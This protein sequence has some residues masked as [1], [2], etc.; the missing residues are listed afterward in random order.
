MDAH[1]VTAAAF[2]GSVKFASMMACCNAVLENKLLSS[3]R[4][5]SRPLSADDFAAGSLGVR[6]TRRMRIGVCAGFGS[7]GSIA[8]G[9][10]I[11]GSGASPG[12]SIG[13]GAGSGTGM[14]ADGSGGTL[15]GGT[16]GSGAGDLG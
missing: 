4:L 16:T 3:Y 2:D 5:S 6:F 7:P 9:S 10:V 13:G 14:P 8:S 12:F 15:P 11:G 1:G